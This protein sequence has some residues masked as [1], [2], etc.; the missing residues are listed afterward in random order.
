MVGVGA[1]AGRA[2]TSAALSGG[3]GIASEMSQDVQG[4]AKHTAT[5]IVKQLKKFFA[6][7]GWIP[8]GE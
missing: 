7:Q 2:A 5:E 1:A 4:D 3:V 8:P 6:Q